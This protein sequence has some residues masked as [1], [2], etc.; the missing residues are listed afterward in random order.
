MVA[1]SSVLG[2]IIP[3]S[4]M[5]I[6]YSFV[7]EQSVGEMFLAG[8]IPGLML[9]FAYV[10]AKGEGLVI[11]DVKNPEQPRVHAKETLGGTLNDAEDEAE[12]QSALIA[13]LSSDLAAREDDLAAARTQITS[14]EAQVAA[15]LAD[16]DTA[17]AAVAT[18][19]GEK[20]ELLDEQEAL[21][22]A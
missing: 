17:R 11:L 2:M 15:L 22:L 4:A 10:A 18:L 12:R 3:P 16:R 5:L 8:I 1:G 20:A 6:I 19:E 9:A 21:N 13:A 14:F 7:A